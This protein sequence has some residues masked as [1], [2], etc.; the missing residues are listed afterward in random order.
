MPESKTEPYQAFGIF[1]P[2][3]G[4]M[5]LI[6]IF[7]WIFMGI[8]VQVLFHILKVPMRRSLPIFFHTILMHV[9]LGI[10]VEKRGEICR[11][12]PVMFLSNHMSYIDILG[13]G[14]LVPASFIAK[15]EVATWPLIGLL[16]NLQDTV[17]VE[18]R[19]S[20][21]AEQTR[22]LRKALGENKNLVLFPEGTST[23][24]TQVAH[25]K[26]SLMQ[27]LWESDKPIWVQPISLACTGTH[28]Q[29]RR[30]PWIG[31]MTLPPHLWALVQSRGL[32]LCVTFH[33][34][35]LANAF[36]GRK[37]LALYAKEQVAKGPVGVM[38]SH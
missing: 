20:K 18:R 27:V 28:G 3:V 10:R 5:R 30:Y 21:A 15:A 12:R 34:P 38:P 36:Q 19:A 9:L 24:G 35:V 22:V 25:F 31:A 29:E 13:I 33:P 32:K 1:S 16:A 7:T 14:S 6:L 17:F 26:S 23:D 8:P 2:L 11:D 4:V 37:E